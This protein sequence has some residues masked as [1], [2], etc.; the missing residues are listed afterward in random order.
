MK[1]RF[2]VVVGI[3]GALAVVG[4]TAF[5]AVGGFGGKGM[6]GKGER[7]EIMP[8]IVIN[9]LELTEQQMKD[10]LTLTNELSPLRDKILAR[11]DELKAKLIVFK[12]TRTELEEMLKAFR[13]ETQKMVGEFA[14]KAAAGLKEI[15]TEEQLDAI[16]NRGK[17]AIQERLAPM[18]KRAR[19]MLPLVLRGRAGQVAPL[20]EAPKLEELRTQLRE[21]GA[22]M[23]LFR[24][25]PELE[26]ALRAKLGM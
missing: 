18:A 17:Q 3:I 13:E 15:L 20:K 4:L 26:A 7:G 16:W 1:K 19:G 10:L 5:A 6:L 2:W 12:G 22:A 21:K 23:W 8:L 9:A 14:D 11:E 24:H 25:L